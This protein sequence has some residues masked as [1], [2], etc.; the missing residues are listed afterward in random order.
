VIRLGTRGSALA[1]AQAKLVADM[2]GGEVE[3]VTITTSGDRGEA[4]GDKARW[5]SALEAALLAD[6]IDVAVHSAKDVPGDLAD[7]TVI[8]AIPARSDPRDVICGAAAITSLGSAARIGTSSIRRAAQLRALRDDL[9]IVELRGNVD[10]RLRKLADGEADAIVLAYAGLKRLGR[11]SEIGG[12]LDLVPAPGQGAL[13]VQARAGDDRF[14]GINDPNSERCVI[15]ER[16]LASHLNATCN[17]PLGA[18]SVPASGTEVT[19]RTWVGLPDG[20]HWIADELTGP[21][22]EVAQAVAE[23]MRAAGASELLQ[24]AEEMAA[25]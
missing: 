2:L 7:G 24:R 20:S 13:L 18:S 23:R 16:A 25:V 10:T 19:L 14:A 5:T 9:Q 3:L 8:A 17:T 15:A 1:L 4:L 21:A 6:E 22:I 12:V 11:E